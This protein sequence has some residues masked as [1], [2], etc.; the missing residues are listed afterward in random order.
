MTSLPLFLVA[1]NTFPPLISTKISLAFRYGLCYIDM[2]AP[3]DEE[4]TQLPHV[5]MTSDDP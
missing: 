3:T 5:I 2:R 4:L 1:N